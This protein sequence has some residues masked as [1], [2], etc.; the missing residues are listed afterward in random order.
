M[1]PVSRRWL[2][3]SAV[4]GLALPLL[5]SL[6][7]TSARAEGE[8]PL[9]FVFWYVPNGMRMDHWRPDQVG[10]DYDLKPILAPLAP[11][12]ADVAVLTGL[13]NRPAQVP[14]PGDHARGT[15]SFLTCRTVNHT[16]GADIRNGVSIDQVLAG[17]YQGQTTLPSLELGIEGGASTGICDSGYSCAYPRNIA[18]A[19][20][21]TPLPKLTDPRLVF[22]RLFAGFDPGL[23]EEEAARR[24]A[25]RLS[26]LDHAVDEVHR[27]E[28]KLSV[29]DRLKLDE[30]L[31]A[32]RALELRLQ[33]GPGLVCDPP[34]AP[35]SNLDFPAT[36]EAMSELT[37]IALQC[38]LTRVVS[39]MLGNG[40]SPRSF[41]FI[42]APGAHHELSHHG[43]DPATNDKLSLIGAWEVA[44]YASLVARLADT[45]DLNGGRLLDNTLVYFSSEISDGDRHNHDD[46]PVLLAG[47]PH[48]QQA[49]EH[50]VWGETPMADL[51][52]DMIL[53][54]G[55]QSQR[56]GDD[57]NGPLGYLG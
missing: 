49:G 36:I 39:F 8:P 57:G 3:R 51:F 34:E 48:L 44:R 43:G 35:G 20:E 15:G 10:A 16:A 5:P 28:P 7:R 23:S 30:Y 1:S 19:G 11:V 12:Q 13:A 21:A 22:D 4:A 37:A 52:S 50:V 14:V 38:D 55:G 9:R 32:V 17:V 53:A 56:F 24:L 33:S 31:T 6:L 25:L 42:G 29:S 18:W 40:G 47:A 41:E 46:L 45:P 27:L 54:A 26:V 2:L